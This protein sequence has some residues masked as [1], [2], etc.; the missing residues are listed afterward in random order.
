M[1]WRNGMNEFDA[2]MNK[3]RHSRDW[4]SWSAVD[5]IRELCTEKDAVKLLAQMETGRGR[6][7]TQPMKGLLTGWPMEDGSTGIW[8]EAVVDFVSLLPKSER[9]ARFRL[10]CEDP[11]NLERINAERVRVRQEQDDKTAKFL[12]N[13][14][15][16]DFEDVP[17]EFRRGRY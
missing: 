14:E 7:R 11:A 12:E 8:F 5:L 15:D 1:V 3:V 17:W 9:T 6:F 4:A 2:I 13:V 16:M 10:L